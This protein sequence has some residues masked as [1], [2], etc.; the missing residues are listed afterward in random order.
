MIKEYFTNQTIES[1][2]KI[3]ESK[4]HSFR[5]KNLTEKSV[6][7][8]DTDK[9]ILALAAAKGNIPDTELEN[10][11]IDLLSLN[12]PYDYEH[13]KN[14]KAEFTKD[15]LSITDLE[16]FTE[17]VLK[18]L[19][20][21][22]KNYVLWGTGSIRKRI[23]ALKNNLNLDLSRNSTCID[24]SFGMKLK[25]SGN[26]MD[27]GT[28][29]ED[30]DITDEKYNE[31]LKDSDFI[32][33]AG[34]AEE[35]KLENKQYKILSS[36]ES[37]LTMFREDI[38]GIKYEE[39]SSLLA[40][41]LGENIFHESV[42]INESRVN[43]DM[44]SFV[45]FDH[46][47]IITI[48]DQVI[49]QNGILKTIVY[50]KKQAKKYGKEATGNGYRSYNTNPG[51]SLCQFSF[52]SADFQSAKGGFPLCSDLI[53]DDIVIVPYI[54]SGGN[55][56]DNGNYSMPVQMA[57]VFKNGKFIGKAPQITLTGNYLESMNKDFV[58]FG[59]NDILKNALGKTLILS[60]S[61]V[62]V[63]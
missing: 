6:R 14:F 7:V 3:K 51:I 12:M 50:D 40:G 28:G 17:K 18:D 42:S 1:A 63:I 53:S 27:S 36:G 26:I 49:V 56:L 25:G 61:M 33:K 62:N 11:A 48:N 15:I 4:I 24:I 31:F 5:N 45:P 44:V 39:K 9:K 32:A 10:K 38:S 29:I 8:F 46:E 20:D 35:V 2:I 52:R 54:C 34:M 58:S 16:G 55:F 47:G 30:Y 37:L 41:K 43:D 59:K 19:S 57:F 23:V 13:E 21:I 22:S 60:H